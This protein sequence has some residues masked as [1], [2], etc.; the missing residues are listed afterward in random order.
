MVGLHRL[1]QK[2]VAPFLTKHKFAHFFCRR[3]FFSVFFA[4]NVKMGLSCF[5]TLFWRHLILP[6]LHI[7]TRARA[8]ARSRRP[9]QVVVKVDAKVIEEAKMVSSKSL[10]ILSR[11]IIPVWA[12]NLGLEAYTRT[13]ENSSAFLLTKKKCSGPMEILK[14]YFRS[15]C[16]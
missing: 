6:F 2:Q 4:K 11:L 14:W 7:T 12:W 16:I 1:M 8:R 3:D 13:F 15:N 9:R 5:V 10:S